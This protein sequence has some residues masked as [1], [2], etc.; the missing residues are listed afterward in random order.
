MTD[1]PS[2]I[3]LDDLVLVRGSDADAVAE[4]MRSEL[5]ERVRQLNTNPAQNH[6]QTEPEPPE[7]S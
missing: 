3:I 1:R 2:V 5:I 7:E 4:R 6:P